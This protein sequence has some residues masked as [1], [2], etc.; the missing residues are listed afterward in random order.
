MDWSD[1]F[2]D[3]FVLLAFKGRDT[4]V[5]GHDGEYVAEYISPVAIFGF[6]DALEF[7]NNNYI[8]AI[9]KVEKEQYSLMQK[10]KPHKM[11]GRSR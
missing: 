9:C 2:G 3:S 7:Y 1:Q 5:T 8:E 11:T 10:E 4:Y 6:E